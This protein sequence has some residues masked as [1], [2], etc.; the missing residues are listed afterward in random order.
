MT[1]SG[2]AATHPERVTKWTVKRPGSVVPPTCNDYDSWT[3]AQLR[4]ECTER[5]LR[6]KGRLANRTRFATSGS[7]MLLNVLYSH[8]LMKKT[9]WTQRNGRQ[10][11]APFGF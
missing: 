7:T 8:P 9:C 3:V 1:D 4:K 10:N 5:K 6:L 2:G 11:I